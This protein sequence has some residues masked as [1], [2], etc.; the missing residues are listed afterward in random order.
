MEPVRMRPTRT[1]RRRLPRRSRQRG[2]LLGIVIV[3]LAVLFTAGIFALWSMRG[4]TSSA[5]RDRLQRQLFDCAEQGLAYG[6]QYFA[7]HQSALPGYLGANVCST[8]IST[9]PYIG[10]LPCTTSGGPFPTTGSALA[11]YPDGT[12]FTQPI[13]MDTRNN[14]TT[15]DFTFT[16]AVYNDP[17]DPTTTVDAN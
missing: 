4:D 7:S 9:S 2:V 3:L 6:K 13:V 16:F 14:N 1:T 11:G 12:P 17:A 8:T 10:P 5:G 15:A